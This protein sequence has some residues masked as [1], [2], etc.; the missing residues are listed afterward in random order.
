MDGNAKVGTTGYDYRWQDMPALARN[1]ATSPLYAFHYLKKGMRR[2]DNE[3]MSGYKASIYNQIVER[4][5]EKGVDA[6]SHARKLTER[7]RRFYRHKKGRLNSNAVLRPISE[8][9]KVLLNADLRLFDDDEALHE[10]VRGRLEKF[11]ERVDKKKAD[12]SIPGWLY[13]NQ[14]T[15]LDELNAAVDEFARY[16][17]LTIYRDVFGGDR[18]AIAGKQLN[19]LKNACESVYMAEQRREWRERNEQPDEP[20][21][22]EDE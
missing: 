6:M 14:E 20:I 5:L 13:P 8:A 7:Y 1:L 4:Y 11:V 16:F 15:R 9:A 17:V 22:N 12:G 19:L 3:V 10:I 18:A 2:T 21:D